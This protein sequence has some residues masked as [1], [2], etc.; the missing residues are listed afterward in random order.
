MC[1]LVIRLEGLIGLDAIYRCIF[2]LRTN[3]CTSMNVE[4]LL[5]CLGGANFNPLLRVPSSAGVKLALLKLKIPLSFISAFFLLV[6]LPPLVPRFVLD[7]VWDILAAW[8]NPSN[9]D[10][11]VYPGYN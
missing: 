2:N 10:I 5:S 4:N 11:L 6:L 3:L 9:M 1:E 7:F 8:E